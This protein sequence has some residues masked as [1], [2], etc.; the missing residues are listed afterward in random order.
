MDVPS[1]ESDTRVSDAASAF[2]TTSCCTE[3]RASWAS[4][5]A[6]ALGGTDSTRFV[7]VFAAASKRCPM[8]PLRGAKGIG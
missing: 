2:R 3:S 7:T 5:P 6:T 4:A 8:R 1:S